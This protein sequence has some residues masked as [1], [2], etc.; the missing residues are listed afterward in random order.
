MLVQKIQDGE[1]GIAQT[2]A[3][4]IALSHDPETT[5]EIRD[6][7]LWIIN[8]AGATTEMQ[9][10]EAIYNWMVDRV[11]Y[12]RD[13]VYREF[14]QPPIN[15]LRLSFENYPGPPPS[16]SAGDCDD[17]A[18]AIAALLSAAGFLTRFV[19]TAESVEEDFWS[20]I[21]VEVL[22]GD[23]WIP[24]DS[25]MWFVKFNQRVG[26]KISTYIY[27]GD[28]NHD[29]IYD[30]RKRNPGG[31]GF[32]QHVVNRGSNNVLSQMR[33]RKNK[34]NM[35]YALG[36]LAAPATQPTG[37]AFVSNIVTAVGGIVQTGISTVGKVMIERISGKTEKEIEKIRAQTQVVLDRSQTSLQELQ[38]KLS[39]EAQKL[40]SQQQFLVESEKQALLDI[41]AA[42]EKEKYLAI[43]IV[44]APM[45]TFVALQIAKRK[46]RS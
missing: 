30:A 11:A 22:V 45:V 3:A 21:Y 23:N 42:H 32:V 5:Q 40:L 12:N 16:Q 41:V 31:I 27:P 9:K 44:A 4:M 24:V 37:L 26:A 2:V 10:A 15:L 46:E 35:P 28:I 1:M 17:H 13:P 6:M 14:V 8:N 36:Q 29:D 7:A 18:T 19:V 34:P 39:A 25:S 38:L 20:H 33:V 43:A